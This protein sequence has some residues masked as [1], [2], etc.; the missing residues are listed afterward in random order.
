MKKLIREVN[1]DYLKSVTSKIVTN[2]SNLD[3]PS[4]LDSVD[5]ESIS[6]EM[7][8]EVVQELLNEGYDIVRYTRGGEFVPIQ[9]V[10]IN[11]Q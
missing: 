7:V 11:E 1:L 4:L 3:N 5:W 9:K 6:R 10:V 2:N 8:K